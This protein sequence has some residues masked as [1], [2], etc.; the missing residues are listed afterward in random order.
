[1]VESVSPLKFLEL[2]GDCLHTKNT[3]A[4]YSY[5]GRQ[6]QL[7]FLQ[8]H[9]IS[10]APMACDEAAD[11]GRPLQEQSKDSVWLKQGWKNPTTKPAH[12]RQSLHSPCPAWQCGWPDLLRLWSHFFL[13][14]YKLTLANH[15]YHVFLRK[16][17]DS[18]RTH[19]HLHSTL[20]AF[21]L[22]LLSVICVVFILVF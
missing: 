6:Q 22:K 5:Y 17:T 15:L 7:P 4:C 16:R 8:R 1:M 9:S 10:E 19:N 11:E 21:C 18:S 12:A 13:Q 3:C 2:T 20:R 14:I